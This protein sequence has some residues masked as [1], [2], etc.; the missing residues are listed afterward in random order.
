MSKIICSLWDGRPARGLT[1]LVCI[2]PDRAD[3]V[4]E[5][6]GFMRLGDLQI[7]P[8]VVWGDVG[9]TE[10]F[11]F[12]AFGAEQIDS[13]VRELVAAK[14]QGRFRYW[15]VSWSFCD[16][17]GAVLKSGLVFESASGEIIHHPGYSDADIHDDADVHDD[18]RAPEAGSGATDDEPL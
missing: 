13:L 10:K 9:E 12:E 14:K 6:M 18:Q 17:S 15:L 16:E 2:I 3:E 7:G 8:C 11:H 5:L 4:V 1:A